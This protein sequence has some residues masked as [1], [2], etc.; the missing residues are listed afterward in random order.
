MLV[1]ENIYV[2]NSNI[3]NS[4][5]TFFSIRFENIRQ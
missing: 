5:D 1:I 4:G 3:N 2:I